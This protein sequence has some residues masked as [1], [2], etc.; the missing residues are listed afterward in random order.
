MTGKNKRR[1]II[2]LGIIF[3]V[4][5]AGLT[6]YKVWSPQEI[7][8]TPEEEEILMTNRYEGLSRISYE[9]AAPGIYHQESSDYI[10][11]EP[12]WNAGRF[13]PWSELEK[14]GIM[15]VRQGKLSTPMDFTSEDYDFYNYLAVEYIDGMV[16]LPDHIT[17]IAKGTFF[18]CNITGICLPESLEHIGAEAFAQCHLLEEIH[19]PQNVKKL[20][21]APFAGCDSLSR[22]TV[23]EENRWY[24]SRDNC[25]AIIRTDNNRLIAGCRETVIPDDI[26]SVEEHAYEN[27]IDK[28][29]IDLP[30][31]DSLAG[32]NISDEREVEY[33]PGFAEPELKSHEKSEAGVYSKGYI[34]YTEEKGIYIEDIRTTW[35]QLEQEGMITIKDGVLST[36][37]DEEV[38][39]YMTRNYMTGAVVLP[40]LVKVV[41]KDTFKDCSIEELIIPEGVET[42]EDDAFNACKKLTRI[43]LPESLKKI[44]RNA[45]SHCGVKN[46][47][48]PDGVKRIGSG[49]FEGITHIEYKGTAA[50]KKDSK[51]WG[52]KSMN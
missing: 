46:L 16:V 29:N 40:D 51:Y 11:G 37:V 15:I 9:H 27:W 36:E 3:I 39:N 17:S 31:V 22:I 28:K 18:Q 13:I 6:G 23:S 49:A 24:D 19:L 47:E 43:T 8:D 45:F 1:I 26:E 12:A 38:G 44:G 14:R 21:G 52:A 48:V 32:D 41:A 10:N 35:Q 20:D 7:T 42:I 2:I 33:P 50:Y 30:I 5:A 34:K 25:N 4:F